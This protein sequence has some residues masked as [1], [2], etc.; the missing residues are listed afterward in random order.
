MTGILLLF[1]MAVASADPP[2]IKFSEVEIEKSFEAYL[3]LIRY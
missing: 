2:A 3:S 1:A